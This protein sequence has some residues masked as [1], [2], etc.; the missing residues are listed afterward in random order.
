MNFKEKLFKRNKVYAGNAVD[1]YVDQIILPD[2]KLASR[3]YLGH[4]GAVAVIPFVNADEI[5][6]VCQYRYPVG[7]LTWEIPAGK[8]DKNEKPDLCVRRELEEETG[9]KAKK[10]K[11]LISY[12]PT[13]AFANEVLHV[14]AAF[15]LMQSVKSPDE[16]EFIDHKIFS[17]KEALKL[18]ETGKI[19]DSK[20]IIALLYWKAFRK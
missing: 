15:G 20:T 16:D 5:I 1:F 6:L 13:P 4:P 3:E 9:F 11:K 10:I 19:M 2:G 14:Y 8:L 12:W 18:V 7:K 17:F